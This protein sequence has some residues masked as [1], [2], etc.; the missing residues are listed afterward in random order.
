LQWTWRLL[1]SALLCMPA[2]LMLAAGAWN[3]RPVAS[4]EPR[5]GF[6][7]QLYSSI[8]APLTISLPKPEAGP[9][10]A[11]AGQSEMALNVPAPA[12]PPLPG[13]QRNYGQHPKVELW[14]AAAPKQEVPTFLHWP[15]T[16][17]PG[18]WVP[19]PNQDGGG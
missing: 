11:G 10:M 17:R 16:T 3:D 2:I 14:Y 12:N 7:P 13:P 19:G 15:R 6:D 1:I 4:S 18:V 8:S 5:Y 9:V